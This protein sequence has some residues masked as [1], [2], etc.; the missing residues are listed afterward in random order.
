MESLWPQYKHVML[1]AGDCPAAADMSLYQAAAAAQVC[2]HHDADHFHWR[3]SVWLRSFHQLT[4]CQ[5]HQEWSVAEAEVW[6]RSGDGRDRLWCHRRQSGIQAPHCSCHHP[7]QCHVSPWQLLLHPSS[8]CPFL[9]QC[10]AA[11]AHE[12][13]PCS[14][15]MSVTLHQT[16]KGSDGWH[17]EHVFSC[18]VTL[19]APQMNAHR[20][21]KQVQVIVHWG[22]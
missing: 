14:A 2:R 18:Q 1:F 11:V 21:S 5:G 9:K 8:Y 19:A 6:L 12:A 15:A 4:R 17:F 10:R 7:P 13:N 22:F 3:T 16:A 20:Q